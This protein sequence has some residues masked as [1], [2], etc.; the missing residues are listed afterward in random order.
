[1]NLPPVR[2]LIDTGEKRVDQNLPFVVV[3]HGQS[4][5]VGRNRDRGDPVAALREFAEI[6]D[7]FAVPEIDR[8]DFGEDIDAGGEL[9]FNQKK[10]DFFL[11]QLKGTRFKPLACEGT[12]F[13]ICD[14]SAI[15]DEPDLDF[16]KRLTIEHGVAAIPVSSFYSDGRDDKVIRFCFAKT[17]DVLARAGELLAKV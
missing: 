10:R 12:Y 7:E 1:M 4:P 6:A 3:C 2:L 13:Q 8:F 14:Y 9:S 17:E 11:E 15:S 16:C 5:S